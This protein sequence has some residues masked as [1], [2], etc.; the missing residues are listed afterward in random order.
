MSFG[1]TGS[2][3]TSITIGAVGAQPVLAGTGPIGT[4][5]VLPFASTKRTSTL[6]VAVALL[7]DAKK[8]MSGWPIPTQIVAL[9]ALA[10]LGMLSEWLSFAPPTLNGSFPETSRAPF[11]VQFGV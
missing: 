9:V 10:P 8:R 4:D 6:R 5:C 11:S 3:L 2:R 7:P 1:S